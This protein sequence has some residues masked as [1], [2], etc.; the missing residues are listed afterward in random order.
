VAEESQSAADRLLR[1]KTSEVG[2][3]KPPC[4]S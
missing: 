3:L 1:G 2:N 4:T